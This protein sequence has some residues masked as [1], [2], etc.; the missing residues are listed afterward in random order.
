[1]KSLIAMRSND[2]VNG[3]DGIF[4]KILPPP[5]LESFSQPESAISRILTVGIRVFFIVAGLV[6]LYYMLWGGFDWITSGGQKE[7]LET[8]RNRLTNA[9]I[10]LF[11]IVL[12]LAIVGTLEQLAF[13]HQICFGI[14]CGF[15][16]PKIK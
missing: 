2:T 13:K 3:S 11:F 9:I 14:T 6:A 12:A 8:A 15:N 7:K 1:M 4:G 5:G 10:G 16:I